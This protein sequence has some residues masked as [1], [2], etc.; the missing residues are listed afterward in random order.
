[1]GQLQLSGTGRIMACPDTAHVSMSIT[2]T[3]K[4]SERALGDNNKQ[5]AKLLE[6]L[7]GLGIDKQDIKTT[8]F[9]IQPVRERDSKGNVNKKI[10]HWSV[11]NASSVRVRNLPALGEILAAA[12]ELAQVNI[13]SFANSDLNR[14]LDEARANAIKDAQRKARIYAE[15]GGFALGGIVELSESYNYPQPQYGRRMGAKAMAGGG[16]EA[17]CADVPMS[18]GQDEH[19]VDVHVLFEITE[20]TSKGSG[21]VVDAPSQRPKP[22]LS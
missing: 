4:S 9:N 7:V 18:E 6:V 10:D 15:A 13:S 16:V 11:V 22:E 3:D 2:T 20:S 5:V 14:L 1:M 21:E 8:V 17:C 19:T 12:G